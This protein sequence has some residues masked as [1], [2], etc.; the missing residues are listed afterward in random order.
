M[1]TLRETPKDHL[2]A[3]IILILSVSAVLAYKYFYSID[4]PNYEPRLELHNQIISGVAPSPY[5]YRVLVPFTEEFIIKALSTVSST[6]S[7]FLTS[8]A[9]YDFAAIFFLLFMLLLW[10]K[11]WFTQEQALIGTLFTAGTMPM[12]LQNHYFQPWSLLEAGLFSAALLLIYQ[13]RHFLLAI[14]VALASMNR[15]TAIFIPLAFLTTINFK[16]FLK[17]KNID[18]RSILFFCGLILIWASVFLGVRY[19]RGDA[20]HVETIRSLIS[21]NTAKG[22]LSKT[23]VNIILFLGGMW[24]F[25]FR[26]FKYSPRIIQSFAM[27]IPI[28]LFTII[29]WGVW[30][31]VR[32]L[33]PL[34][35][36]LLPMGLSFLYPNKH[37]ITQNNGLIG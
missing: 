33:M 7:A 27:I 10:L 19:L 36:I 35:P 14:L 13:K 25:A 29:I 12:V 32:L 24:V 3:I 34:Y 23:F 26:G 20:P 30:Y 8:Y 21:I 37:N 11:T 15:E 17:H 28:Y 2:R 1:K 5:R 18:W 16:A 9:L 31:E 4:K 22:S 6:K